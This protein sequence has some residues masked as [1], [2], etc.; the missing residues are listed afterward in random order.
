MKQWLEKTHRPLFEL[1]RHFLASFFDSDLITAPGQ[2]TPVLIGTFTLLIPWFPVILAP[3]REKYRYLFHLGDQHLYLQAVRADELWLITLVMSAIGLLTAVKWQSVFPDLRDYRSLASLPLR[4]H[5]IFLARFLALLLIATPIIIILNLFP[6]LLFPAISGSQW[7][8]N[9][10]FGARVIAHMIA[11][12]AGSY[13]FF[14][15]LVALQGLLLILLRR[16]IFS[17]VSGYLQGILVSAMLVLNVLSFSI[18]PA[19]T[20]EALQPA[21]ERWLPPVWFLG[22]EQAMLGDSDPQMLLLAHRAMTALLISILLSL[23]T[24]VVSYHRH[25][26][27]FLGGYR[28]ANR[29]QRRLAIPSWFVPEPRRQAVVSF[30]MKTLAASSQH[31]TILMGYIGFGLA[32]LLS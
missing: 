29:N 21:L 9:P 5:Q 20:N 14:F 15:G 12:I 27:I 19:V 16:R 13:F 30:I 11:G 17:F 25:R 10:S 18:Q 3:L 26:A 31:R 24:Y 23:A 1:L 4:A 22:L 6:S 28:S 2:M 7:A 32:I 8:I